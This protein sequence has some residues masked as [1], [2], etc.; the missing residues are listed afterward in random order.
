[1]ISTPVFWIVLCLAACSALPS[2]SLTVDPASSA[3]KKPPLVI[4]S[5]NITTKPKRPQV[6]CTRRYGNGLTHASCES[7][8][9][10]IP[11]ESEDTIWFRR[12]TSRDGDIGLPYRFLSGGSLIEFNV[13]C[14][15]P[16]VKHLILT[17][18]IEDGLCAID[19]TMHVGA[20]DELATWHD[21]HGA[22]KEIIERCVRRTGGIAGDFPRLGKSCLIVYPK[23]QTLIS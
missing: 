21:I 10:G 19:I 2:D 3:S 16:Y 7:A 20:P 22:A 14:H 1:M 8:L 13:A 18:N 15:E 12:R 11:L 6:G 4:A 9:N 5:T 23:T 17:Q